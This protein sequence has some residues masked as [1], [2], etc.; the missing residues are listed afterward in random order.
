MPSSWAIQSSVLQLLHLAKLFSIRISSSRQ[1]GVAR[2]CVLAC[3]G[4]LGCVVSAKVAFLAG[5]GVPRGSPRPSIRQTSFSRPCQTSGSCV[6][7]RRRTK[8][9]CKATACDLLV[10]RYSR[11]FF[12]LLQSTNILSC[13]SQVLLLLQ[14]PLASCLHRTHAISGLHGSCICSFLSPY[15]FGP[16]L[17]HKPLAQLE[18]QS[19]VGLLED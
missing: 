10:S 17:P 9:A 3:N 12:C 6:S 14:G 2:V 15:L 1:K 4:K 13:F 19:S 7:L 5:G 11:S 16:L 18:Q 8:S